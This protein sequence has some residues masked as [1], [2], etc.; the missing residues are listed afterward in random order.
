[1]SYI[2]KL[3]LIL[4]FFIFSSTYVFAQRK[5]SF[6][7]IVNPVRIS[8]YTKD[9]ALSLKKE[10]DVVA[11]RNLSATWLLT[12]DAISDVSLFEIFSS[13]D[14]KQELGIF[15]EVTENFSNAS[16]ISYNKTNSW[17]YA[18][19][20]FLSGHKQGDR[21]KLIDEVFS[22]FKNKFGYYP[23][24][25]GG[26]WVDSFSLSYM[27]QKY[28]ITG[29]LGLSDQFDLDNY[30]VWG[31]PYSIPF[32]PSK[33][34][35]G[36]P[37]DSPNKLDIVTFRWAA[38]DPLNGYVSPSEKQASPVRD[39]SNWA[40]LYSVQD[41]PQVGASDEYFERLIE[42]YSVQNKYNE[43]GHLTIG[44]E[45]DY[46][47]DIYEAIFA[48]RLDSVREFESQ[49]VRVLTMEQ[50]SNWYRNEFKVMPPHFIEADDLLGTP[51]KAMWYQ[52]AFYRIGLVYDYNSRKLRIVDLRPYQNNFQEPF[53]I[54]PNKQF[55]LSINLP[56]VIDYMND[57]NSV[58][59]INV[60]NLESISREGNY[61]K[62]KFEKE[63]IIFREN[64][65][66]TE[67]ISVPKI[68]NDRKFNVAP[69]ELVLSDFSFNI[70]FSIKF[71]LEQYKM[72]ISLILFFSGLLF[73]RTVQRKKK[74][75]LYCSI[76]LLLLISW[77]FIFL[78]GS[79]Y[80]ISQTEV[81]G[82]SVLERLPKG[83][84]LAYDKDCIR[85]KF[86]TQYKPAAA[87]GIKSYVGRMSGQ[88]TLIDFSFSIAKTSK[89]ARK[90]LENKNIDYVYL[91]KYE[92][93]IE[94]L[95]YL[96]QD[97]GLSKIYSNANTEIWKIN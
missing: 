15:L 87:R 13:M 61:I 21:K 56:Y 92:D 95:P 80:Y 82:L 44:L 94:H 7:T 60:G 55:N 63:S 66:L 16:G 46:S 52:S 34:H 62:L 3:L 29:V 18:N 1:M 45:A 2:F 90:I 22:E 67:E 69:E 10:Y 8:S 72:P 35:A 32:Y 49:G 71:R 40:S 12:Y 31:T 97:L 89:D 20:L 88:E 86:E 85:C 50:F 79:K 51:K 65:I 70:P 73:I 27:K 76:V 24:S 78:L 9:P 30:Q 64:E 81:D 54:S 4:V 36:I 25:V 37:G 41:Y 5:E 43:F 83:R 17:H 19:A 91:V 59:E 93:Y 39:L 38:R 53:Y 57:K 42:L 48:K 26:W 47:P 84:V 33:I 28:G 58:R 6:I 11:E 68:M 14:G 74:L 77:Y 96:P 23:K 75:L